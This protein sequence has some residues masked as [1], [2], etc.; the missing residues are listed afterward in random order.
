MPGRA[1]GPTPISAFGSML[2]GFR[3]EALGRILDAPA[4]NA[5]SKASHIGKRNISGELHGLMNALDVGLRRILV[6]N[7]LR[8]WASVLNWILIGLIVAAAFIPKLAGV[9]IAA[10]ILTIIGC[11]AFAIWTWRTRPSPYG[12]ACQ[13]DSAAGFHD[14]TS[15]ALYFGESVQ[16]EEIIGSQR[17]DAL[18]RLRQLDVRALFPFHA[19]PAARR[20]LLLAAAVAGLFTY[21]MYYRPPLT[22]LLQSSSSSRLVRA[23]LAPLK[24]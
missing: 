23:L 13:L 9:T 5:F 17:R 12:V 2:S 6:N 18:A 3:N 4:T 22:A 20:T 7:L 1:P 10:A 15:T 8:G 19:P 21:R 24:Q 14:R 16:P 11:A